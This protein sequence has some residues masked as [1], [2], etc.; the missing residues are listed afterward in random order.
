MKNLQVIF[1]DSFLKK[2]SKIKDKKFKIKII[3]QIKKLKNNPELGKPMRN[4]RK[5]TR[6]LY[7]KPFRISYCYFK[8]KLILLML[9]IYH[10]DKQ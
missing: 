1:E 2:F 9:D 10:K 6:E 4:I 8:D 5:N 3:K 7:I